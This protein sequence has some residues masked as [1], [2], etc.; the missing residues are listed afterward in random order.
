MI[1]Y[2]ITNKI[3]N[4]RYVGITI[5]SIQERFSQHSNI[6]IKNKSAINDAIRKYGKEN[7]DV[8]QIDTASTLEELKQ[9]EIYWIEKLGTF[10]HE[11]NLTKGGDGMLGYK[12]KEITK[13]KIK[14]SSIERMKNEDVRKHLSEKTKQYFENHPEQ[15]LVLSRQQK[16]RAAA[17]ISKETCEKISKALFGKKKNWSIEGKARIGKSASERMKKPRSESFK[18]KMKKVM[19][20]NNPMCSSKHREAVRLSKIGKKRFYRED[21]S[22]YMS[23]PENP[24]DPKKKQEVESWQ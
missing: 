12:F 14:K 18:L 22:F 5:R 4:K 9:K 2:L 6:N 17:G 1:V 21:G 16:E 10:Q 7:F 8:V 23:Y 20:E 13:E 19:T 24:I 11:Y 15:K 3:N